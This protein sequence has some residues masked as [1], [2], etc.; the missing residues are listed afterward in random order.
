MPMPR[1]NVLT[2]ILCAFGMLI[3]LGSAVPLARAE[4]PA[5][6]PEICTVSKNWLV[7]GNCGMVA[8]TKFVGTTDNQALVFKT[9]KIERGGNDTVNERWNQIPGRD[10]TDN[11][12]GERELC[13]EEWRLDDGQ[14]D[15]T[16]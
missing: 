16:E 9:N 15:S 2:L 4:G 12:G 8:G 10:D 13:E 7:K 14:I 6:A 3:L 11:C 5:P 1:R